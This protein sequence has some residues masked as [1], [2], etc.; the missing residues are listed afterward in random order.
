MKGLPVRAK[1]VLTPPAVLNLTSAS[2]RGVAR[3]NPL[4]PRSQDAKPPVIAGRPALL[5]PA[6]ERRRR[7]QRRR[8]PGRPCRGVERPD[9]HLS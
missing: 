2:K 9:T 4:R 8:R 7:K 1:E 6:S 3:R 5:L